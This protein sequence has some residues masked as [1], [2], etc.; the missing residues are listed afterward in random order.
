M[1]A[2]VVPLLHGQ[3][4]VQAVA[5][6]GE[7]VFAAPPAL[8]VVAPHALLRVGLGE[9][10]QLL[11]PPLRGRSRRKVR[12][13]LGSVEAG[14]GDVGMPTTLGSEKKVGGVL[15]ASAGGAL[16]SLGVTLAVIRNRSVLLV[17]FCGEV[18]GCLAG[19]W[20]QPNLGPFTSYVV[21][22]RLPHLPKLA[23]ALGRIHELMFVMVLLLINILL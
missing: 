20:S 16:P 22:D 4:H 7:Q 21:S 9:G 12:N 14:G 18:G 5:R 1:L 2:L 15:G 23:W 17:G 10:G 13:A 11:V 6:D 3:R 19:P 8:L